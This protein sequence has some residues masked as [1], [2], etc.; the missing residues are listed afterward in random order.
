MSSTSRNPQG[1]ANEPFGERE[2]FPAE[3]DRKTNDSGKGLKQKL[4]KQN[5]ESCTY[6]T[7]VEL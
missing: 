4:D 1:E 6:I 3:A 2:S 5:Q 7:C